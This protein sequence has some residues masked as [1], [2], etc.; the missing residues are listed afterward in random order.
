MADAFLPETWCKGPQQCRRPQ[1]HGNKVLIGP[2]H[3]RLRADTALQTLP[4]LEQHAKEGGGEQ[5]TN[6][7]IIW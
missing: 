5:Q 3:P 7:K 4:L 2:A 6:K 1:Q